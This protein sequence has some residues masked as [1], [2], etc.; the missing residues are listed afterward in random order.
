MQ[1]VLDIPRGLSG[2]FGSFW[3]WLR[4]KMRIGRQWHES[5][6]SLHG[7][8]DGPP[9]MLFAEVEPPGSPGGTLPPEAPRAG[10]GGVMPDTAIQRSLVLGWLGGRPMEWSRDSGYAQPGGHMEMR[11]L[12][13]D[14]YSAG[15]AT[16][17]ATLKV[18]PTTRLDPPL[19]LGSA[20]PAYLGS[21]V[22]PRGSLVT[23]NKWWPRDSD[24]SAGLPII[25][26]DQADRTNTAGAGGQYTYIRGR[27]QNDQREF[28]LE[29][30]FAVAPVENDVV[31]L[32]C[33]AFWV[34]WGTQVA[35]PLGH[36][37]DLEKGQVIV[38]WIRGLSQMRVEIYR[39][40]ETFEIIDPAFPFSPN[41]VSH[42][43]SAGGSRD[44]YIYPF[45]RIDQSNRGV[46][47]YQFSVAVVTLLKGGEDLA[48][49]E[50]AYKVVHTDGLHVGPQDLPPGGNV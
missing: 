30:P 14:S 5:W 2:D 13:V 32:G 34:I 43:L 50:T 47:G 18:K 44:P 16:T 45:G 27:T 37:V 48:L 36:N 28:E 4:E 17:R 31:A 12:L 10:Q 29:T 42:E 40:G 24:W 25:I 23:Y 19:E 35:K 1:Y 8:G 22:K 15:D 46:K 49:T 38:R 33:Q 7:G 26:Y 41:V 20:N 6:A 11:D 21:G 9:L 39:S 3:E